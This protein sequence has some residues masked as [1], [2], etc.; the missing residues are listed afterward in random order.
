MYNLLDDILPVNRGLVDMYLGSY[1]FSRVELLL[2]SVNAYSGA[3]EKELQE[4]IQPYITR[5]EARLKDTLDIVDWNI[6][7]MDT[8]SL[9]TGP[10]RFEKVRH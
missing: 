6:D 2:K 3:G 7:S 4:K 8:L 9:I 1:A 5:E 10:G